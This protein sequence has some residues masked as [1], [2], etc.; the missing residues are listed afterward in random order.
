MGTTGL[1]R[2]VTRLL[3]VGFIGRAAPRPLFLLTKTPGLPLAGR[4][5]PCTITAFDI[6]GFGDR[7]RDDEVQVHVRAELYR[8]LRD[9]FAQSGIPWHAC[10]REDRGDGVLV[11]A[12][13]QVPTESFASPLTG[14][15]R[16]GL[17]R[18]NRLSSDIAQIRLRMAV[19]TGQVRFDA[20]GVAGQALVHA[21]RLLEAPVFKTMLAST[22]G[23][24]G[25]I[26]SDRVYDDVIRHATGLIEP[27]LYDDV[28]VSLKETL[29]RAWVHVPGRYALAGMR[30]R[31]DPSQVMVTAVE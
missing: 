19:H 11:V 24:L 6:V 22:R 17:R 26:V 8:V 1:R 10:H 12:P 2:S 23:E 15:V 13:P 5:I 21:Y 16:A 18:H 14:W 9:A 31:S 29:T 4:P 20:H 3:P 27:E 25:L 7:R 28:T 30:Q